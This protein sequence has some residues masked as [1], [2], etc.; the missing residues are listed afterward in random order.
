MLQLSP[1]G[2]LRL[3]AGEGR[4]QVVG[5]KGWAPSL[6]EICR[7]IHGACR[8]TYRHVLDRPYGIRGGVQVGASI[9]EK[10]MRW[11]RSIAEWLELLADSVK[12]ATVL[13]S[14]PVS[15]DTVESEGRLL[16]QCWISYIK[17]KKIK[18]ISLAGLE[19]QTKGKSVFYTSWRVQSGLYSM[20][21]V[22]VENSTRHSHSSLQFLMTILAESRKESAPLDKDRLW[23]VRL[24][25][26]ILN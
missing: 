16:K 11:I 8:S 7:R 1:L 18:I 21:F 17:I 9:A 23:S 19:T 10:R 13:G 26:L 5:T 14:S 25:N 24:E 2:A 20:F 22:R 6:Y 12:V 3:R 4:Q 15:S